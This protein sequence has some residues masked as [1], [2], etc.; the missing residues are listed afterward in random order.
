M[1]MTTEPGQI[2]LE[3]VKELRE[4]ARW[5]N[6]WRS[7]CWVYLTIA[8]REVGPGEEYWDPR[9]YPDKTAAE[10]AALAMLESHLIDQPEFQERDICE[11]VGAFEG[12]P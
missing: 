3:R 7:I 11:Y 10:N 2:S 12:A 4:P 6:R 1:T 8:Q 5:R 9:L